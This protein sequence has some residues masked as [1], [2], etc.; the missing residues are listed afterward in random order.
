MVSL[1]KTWISY[2]FFKDS[3]A[4]CDTEVLGYFLKL[5]MLISC[6]S[7]GGK[8]CKELLT[9]SPAKDLC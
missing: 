3:R 7:E 8:L 2:Q 6:V 1:E 4:D 9:K 5:L